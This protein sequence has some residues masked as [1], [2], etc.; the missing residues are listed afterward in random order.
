MISFKT[1]HEIQ[2]ASYAG[3]IGIMELI[4]FYTNATPSDAAKVK[5]LISS[6]KDKE[7]WDIVQKVI[8]SK[9]HSSVM[10]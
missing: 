4:K 2:E 6:K 8:G 10:D 9:L 7:A 3:N 5:S 1:Y